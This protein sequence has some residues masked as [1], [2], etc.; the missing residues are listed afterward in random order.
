MILKKLVLTG[1]LAAILQW[2]AFPGMELTR[3]ACYAQA[4]TAKN[5]IPEPEDIT[6]DTKDGVTI[7]ATFYPG[8]AKKQAV[9][10]IMIHGWEGQRGEFDALARGLQGLGHAVLCP[11][12][13]GHGGSQTIKL[14][15]GETKTI[16]A[17]GMKPAEME[18]A[19]RDIEACKRFLMEKNNAGEL[20]I[21]ALCVIGADF[22]CTI[23]LK[24]A[25][26]DWNA[27]ILPAY[28]QGQDVKALVLLSPVSAFKGIT[29]RD[30]L[31]HPAIK[32][33]LSIMIVAGAQDSKSSGEA[34]R[35]HKSLQAAR[36]KVPEDVEEQRKKLDLFLVT[37]PVDLEGTKLLSTGLKVPQNIANFIKLRLVDKMD[38]YAWTERRNPLE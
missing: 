9:P 35:V 4:A 1:L 20:N 3:S 32:S 17:K 23:A 27:R 8:T 19:V 12:L 31:L 7:K 33:K 2:A 16:E 28:K 22:G 29:S 10:I 5:K 30:A 6:F 24:W 26:I 15:G 36:P 14:G 21:E 38:E 13:R 25:A 37:P 11:D 34:K 18:L